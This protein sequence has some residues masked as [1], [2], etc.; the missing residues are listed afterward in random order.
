MIDGTFAFVRGIGPAREKQL[1]SLGIHRWSDFPEEGEVL[2]PALDRLIRASLTKVSAVLDEG[3]WDELWEI[4][5]SRER[6]R[7]IPSIEAE[8]CYLDI[9][10]TFD[11]QVT[12]IGCYDERH[13]PRLYV[14]GHNLGDFVRER[15]P[16]AYVTF[17]GASFDLPV[18]ERTFPG[19]TPEAPHLDLRQVAW[20]LKEGG[21]LKAIEARWGL[22][23]PIHLQGLGGAEAPMLWRAFSRTGD[24]ASLRRLLEYNLYDVVQLR[25][26]ARIAYE[27][28]ASKQGGKGRL[29]SSFDRGDVLA[30]MSRTVE[31]VVK[32]AA[33][34]DPDA[35]HEEERRSIRR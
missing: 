10:T 2:S 22:E 27:R 33:R 20:C 5:P 15:A 29:S 17:N 28:L 26:V 13:G 25:M 8:A 6:W 24:E 19:W 34:I 1:R 31:S 3:R 11:G 14:R 16:A 12:V 18:L 21:G 32:R 30:D 9:E 35:F 23:R 4:F 7:F